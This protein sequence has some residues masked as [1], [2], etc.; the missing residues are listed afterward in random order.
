MGFRVSYNGEMGFRVGYNAW[1]SMRV[2]VS[3]NGIQG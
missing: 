2:R 1:K 3:Y